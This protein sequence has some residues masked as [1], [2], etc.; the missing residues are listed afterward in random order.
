MYYLI[1][2]LPVSPQSF[3]LRYIQSHYVGDVQ[4]WKEHKLGQKT[5]LY[6]DGKSTS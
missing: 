1:K 3:Q 2:M 6:G 4:R 5:H